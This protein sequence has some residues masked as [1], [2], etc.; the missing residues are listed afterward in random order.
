MQYKIISS[1]ITGRVTGTP[2]PR[3]RQGMSRPF[4]RYEKRRQTG[5]DNIRRYAEKSEWREC[6]SEQ[7][8]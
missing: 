2:I 4:V 1:E 8:P 3:H 7:K 6:R 5:T